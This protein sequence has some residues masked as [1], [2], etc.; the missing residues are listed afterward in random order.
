[1]GVVLG[2]VA[3][4]VLYIFWGGYVAATLWGWF[5]V[6]LGVM[7]ITYWH[8]VG[9]T[10]VVGALVG[11]RADED[12]N[13]SEALGDAV[14]KSVLKAAIILAML[15]AMGWFAHNNMS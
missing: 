8:A 6:P 14:A 15:L 11:V 4:F 7:A 3:T 5:V 9:L 10:C 12:T 2:L 1:M 13:D